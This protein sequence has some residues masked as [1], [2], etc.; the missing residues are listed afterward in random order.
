[1]DLATSS[2]VGADTF[3]K[4]T[5]VPVMRHDRSHVVDSESTPS[6]ASEQTTS[7]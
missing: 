6:T 3:I 2:T 1:M 4:F 5:I 7:T